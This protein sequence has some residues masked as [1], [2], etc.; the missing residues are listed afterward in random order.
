MKHERDRLHTS[1]EVLAPNSLKIP[2]ERAAY[3]D[4]LHTLRARLSGLIEIKNF[5]M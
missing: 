4:F 5:E 2:M 1:D 3:F